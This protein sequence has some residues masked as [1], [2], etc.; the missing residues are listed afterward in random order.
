MVRWLIA[1][2]VC[3]TAT[4]AASPRMKVAVLPIE[5]VANEPTERLAGE[6]TTELRAAPVAEGN[7]VHVAASPRTI[8]GARRAAQCPTEALAC[9]SAIGASLG[10]DVLIYGKV[11]R[12]SY[13]YQ[14]SLRLLDVTR[15]RVQRSVSEVIAKPDATGAPL[16]A[17]VQSLYARLTRP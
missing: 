15:R 9:M 2:L 16:A 3:M 17:M 7:G 1:I 8:A 5:V 14:I 10:A 4:A 13:G 11:Q 12:R 6:I